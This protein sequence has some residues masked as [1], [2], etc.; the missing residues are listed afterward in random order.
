MSAGGLQF[1]DREEIIKAFELRHFI[2]LKRTQNLVYLD[3]EE[4]NIG[5]EI[6]R[7]RPDRSG[8]VKYC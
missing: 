1:G 7:G 8:R 2:P 5:I 6:D 3:N 4:G